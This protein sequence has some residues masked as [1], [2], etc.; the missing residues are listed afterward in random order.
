[1]TMIKMTLVKFYNKNYKDDLGKVF[2]MTMI[3]MTLVK[4]L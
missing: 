4:F 1:M 3:K 2:I